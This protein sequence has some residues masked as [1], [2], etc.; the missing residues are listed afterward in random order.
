MDEH[1]TAVPPKGWAR[2][3][4]SPIA[5]L[6]IGFLL[7]GVLGTWIS[8]CYQSQRAW[9]E[10]AAGVTD[11]VGAVLNQGLMLGTRFYDA[12]E[13]GAPAD[14]VALRRA[15]FLGQADRFE[16]RDIVDAARICRYFGKDASKMYA[17]VNTSFRYLNA[18]LK[19]YQ[20]KDITK[21]FIVREL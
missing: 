18:H 17:Q 5:R 1:G 16:A 3:A 13:K 12:V 14:S 6:L 10:A 2:V 21:D 15:E 7:T 8:S 4:E 20:N 19:M 9:H 11:S